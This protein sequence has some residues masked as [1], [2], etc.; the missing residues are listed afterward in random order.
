MKL[1][2]L[3]LGEK[4]IIVKVKGHGAFRKRIIEM[5]FVVGQEI[6]I[7]KKAPLKDPVEYNVMGYNVSLRNSEANLIE[8]VSENEIQPELKNNRRYEGTIDEKLLKLNA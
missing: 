6:S 7:V 2:E 4:A 5:G 8:V 3:E 1:S